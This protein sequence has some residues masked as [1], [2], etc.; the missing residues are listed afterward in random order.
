V[1]DIPP[2]REYQDS[3]REAATR[4][5]E[6]AR[7]ALAARFAETDALMAEGDPREVI[8]HEATTWGADLVVL[9]AR[10]LGAIAGALLG[11]VSLGVARHAPCSVLV[12]KPGPA[13]GRR[14]VIAVDGSAPAAAAAAFVAR[15]PLDPATVVQLVGVAQRPVYPATTPAFAT[16]M[17]Q[18]ALAELLRERKD[19]IEHALAEVAG[20][21][22]GTVKTVDRTVLVGHPLEA[23]LGAAAG[24]D[25]GLVV[26]GARGLGHVKRLLLGS[27]S[28]ALLRHVDRPI[29]IVKERA[30]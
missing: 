17:V 27:V 22:A 18:R 25:V 30:G 4:T 29:L 24:R 19:A 11:S 26:A 2:V 21:F 9:G 5:A 6:S 28:E 8:V 12:V 16:G 3:L 15:L 13:A 23:L 20:R 7:A 10:G 14:I 1:L